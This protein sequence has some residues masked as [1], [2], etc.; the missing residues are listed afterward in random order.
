MTV[1]ELI[2]SCDIDKLLEIGAKDCKTKSERNEFKRKRY[3]FIKSLRDI[4]PIYSNKLV[5]VQKKK[6]KYSYYNP[7]VILD[8]NMS[9][10]KSSYEKVLDVERGKEDALDFE[11][12]VNI[13]NDDYEKYLELFYCPIFYAFDLNPIREIL[14]YQVLPGV[15]KKHKHKIVN[16]ILDEM[17]CVPEKEKQD[18]LSNINKQYDK[19]CELLDLNTLNETAMDNWASVTISLSDEECFEAS[20]NS[21]RQHF[22]SIKEI[23]GILTS[24][25]LQEVTVFSIS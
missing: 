21:V 18:I 1:K 5:V 15:Y 23:Y 2:F 22:K 25:K 16:A 6:D 8:F 24:H 11:T 20:K 13:F 14:G 3:N 12:V 19:I 10:L 17:M 7:V 9:Q 4:E